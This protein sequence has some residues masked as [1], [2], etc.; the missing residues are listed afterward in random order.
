MQ[1]MA[2]T[3]TDTGQEEAEEVEVEEAAAA[4]REVRNRKV[5]VRKQTAT[6]MPTTRRTRG[7][8]PLYRKKEKCLT[9]YRMHLWPLNHL[10][11]QPHRYF[12]AILLSLSSVN[13][14]FIL[15]FRMYLAML[16]DDKKLLQGS[17]CSVS[18]YRGYISFITAVKE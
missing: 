18:Y 10:H 5:S 6:P 11:T 4:A 8:N 17:H 12:Q 13:V 9:A 2:D 1:R 16:T 3:T 7:S 14:N 15:T